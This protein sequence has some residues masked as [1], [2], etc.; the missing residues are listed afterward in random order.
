M[1]FEKLSDP[2]Q[3]WGLKKSEPLKAI[4]T[5]RNILS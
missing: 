5:Y 3:S 4:K 1:F 2:Q